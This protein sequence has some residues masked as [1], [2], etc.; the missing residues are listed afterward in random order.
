M[1]R[2]ILVLG[3]V[4]AVRSAIAEPVPAEPAPAAPPPSGAPEGSEA[5]CEA[6]LR[7]RGSAASAPFCKF[8][9]VDV[10]TTMLK[11][12]RANTAAVFAANAG[13]PRITDTPGAQSSS[14]QTAAVAS[15]QPVASAGGSVAAVGDMGQGLQ[16]VTALAINPASIAIGETS[17]KSVWLSRLV[18][19]SLVLPLELDPANG[20][21][22]GF[23]Y[24]GGRLRVNTLAALRSAE[25]ESAIVAYQSLQNMLK[26]TIPAITAAL[27]AA[28]DPAKCATALEAANAVDRAQFCGAGEDISLASAARAARSALAQF[29]EETDRKYLSLEARFDH[30]DLNADSVARKDSLLAAY[31]AAGYGVHGTANGNTLEVRGRGGFVYFQ[32]GGTDQTHFALYGAIGVELAVVRDLKRYCLSLALELTKQRSDDP[33]PPAIGGNAVRIGVAVPLADGRTVSVGVRLPTDGGESTIALSGDWSMLF[34]N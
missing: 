22:R 25:L 5:R 32:D 9:A 30:G 19:V 17:K 29:R 33:M 31:L 10:A 24:I 28:S 16:L 11:A 26:T 8:L 34:G 20:M 3:L 6:A 23:Q 4:L 15:G 12:S 21:K 2:S 27:E 18:D 13:Q 1:K 14:G 7:A